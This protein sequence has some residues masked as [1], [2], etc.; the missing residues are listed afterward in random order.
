MG[1]S[2]NR[3]PCLSRPCQALNP[4]WP[5]WSGERSN[6]LSRCR[7][8][9]GQVVR[10]AGR[11]DRGVQDN[12]RLG[13]PA[14]PVAFD[15]APDEGRRCQF[16]RSRLAVGERSA[17][18]GLSSRKRPH[19]RALG[20]SVSSRRVCNSSGIRPQN[21]AISR[22]SH[23]VLILPFVRLSPSPTTS[24]TPTTTPTNATAPPFGLLPHRRGFIVS[25]EWSGVGMMIRN[26]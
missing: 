15:H 8:R 9:E 22:I 18:E 10:R 4:A 17:S 5:G 23:C 26:W 11:V 14:N 16:A 24:R 7:G 3:S 12:D 19:W 20:V 6:H 25:A 1:R 2:V 21:S 13:I